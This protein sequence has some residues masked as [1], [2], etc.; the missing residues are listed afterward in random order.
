MEYI[1]LIDWLTFT[2][3]VY[4]IDQIAELMDIKSV[5]P[6]MIEQKGY[7]FYEN[8]L[9]NGGITFLYGGK[10]TMCVSLSGQGC[11]TFETFSKLSWEMLFEELIC[12]EETTFNVTRLDIACDVF[13]GDLRLDLIKRYSDKFISGDKRFI[14]TKFE[15]CDCRNTT[16]GLTV[17]YGAMTSNFRVRIY[18]KAKERGY[19]EEDKMDWKR[20]EIQIRKENC[21]Y[22]IM[23]LLNNG[24]FGETFCSIL[25]NY[26]NFI[27]AS[28]TRKVNDKNQTWWDTFIKKANAIRIYTRVEE[29][30]NRRKLDRFLNNNCSSSIKTAYEIGGIKAIENII[31]NA[32][33]LNNKQ[34]FLIN[35]Y[36]GV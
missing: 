10:D 14:R 35:K 28:T 25:T 20:C 1:Y 3:K 26:I 33:P 34:K 11:R 7:W 13:N 30:Y 6:L 32:K 22:A 17:T 8:A 16:D 4:S 27:K 19:S 5:L 36:K 31:K 21:K 2:T 29:E 12:K 24:S 15:Y 9:T 18:D 23:A